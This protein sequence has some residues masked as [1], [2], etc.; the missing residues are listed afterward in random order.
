MD[1]PLIFFKNY[2]IIN[3]KAK[4]VPMALLESGQM[5]LETILILTSESSTVRSIDVCEHM[6][7]SKPSVSRAIGLLKNGGYINV[8]PD[9]FITLTEVGREV[10][11]KIYDRHRVLTD[12]L[13]SLGVDGEVASN[14]A[15][16]IEHH[17]SDESFEAIKKALQG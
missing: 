10:A 9:G 15:C 5:Y 16:K 3:K 14:D 11:Q 2:A 13:I 4:E 12:F 8:D 6:G 1:I 7:F 17:I